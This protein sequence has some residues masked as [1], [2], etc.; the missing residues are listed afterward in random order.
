MDNSSKKSVDLTKK[1]IFKSIIRSLILRQGPLTAKQIKE[2]LGLKRQTTYNYLKELVEEGRVKTEE[3]T[4]KDRPNLKVT[5]Y[6]RVPRPVIVPENMTLSEVIKQDAIK[7]DSET[8]SKEM[9]EVVEDTLTA[10]IEIRTLLHGMTDK[11]IESYVKCNP[12][13][14]GFFSPTYL[15]TDDEY[16]DWFKEFKQLLDNLNKKRSAKK[17]K[18]EPSKQHV[19]SLTFFKAYPQ[20]K[21]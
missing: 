7:M 3:K 1:S 15:L 21:I 12:E 14:W 5:Y 13:V 9:K 19:F 20:T 18:Q 4:V 16:N 2:K 10:I 6:S 8:F 17:R 11:E